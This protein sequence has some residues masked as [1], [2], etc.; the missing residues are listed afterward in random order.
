MPPT[1][2]R[3]IA[4]LTSAAGLGV[5]LVAGVVLYRPLEE[6]YWLWKLREGDEAEKER[7]ADRLAELKVQEAVPILIALIPD[8]TEPPVQVPGFNTVVPQP[9]YSAEAL[10]KFGSSAVPHLRRTFLERTGAVRLS[11]A[12]ILGEIG[13]DA[14]EAVPDLVALLK[15]ELVERTSYFTRRAFVLVVR[16][17]LDKIRRG[18]RNQRF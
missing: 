12:Y 18:Q 10:S 6:R 7:A 3:A 2:K 9:H 16:D 11:A 5:L 1:K 4:L 15:N 14:N 17:A 8:D 13:S